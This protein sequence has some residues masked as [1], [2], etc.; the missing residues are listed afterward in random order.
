MRVDESTAAR[1]TAG[2]S[3]TTGEQQNLKALFRSP[4]P[5][6]VVSVLGAAS[7]LAVLD[8]VKDLAYDRVHHPDRPLVTG[9]VSVAPAV[10]LLVVTDVVVAP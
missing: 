5:P 3:R 6:A 1:D 10:T 9:E 4:F 7:V 2:T 8:E